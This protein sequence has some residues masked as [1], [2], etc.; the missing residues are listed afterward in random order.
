M[1]SVSPSEDIMKGFTTQLQNPADLLKKLKFDLA[2][3]ERAPADSYVA[4]DFFVTAEHLP[5]WVGNKQVKSENEILKVV[6]HI[7][8][9]AKHFKVRDKRHKSVTSVETR[10]DPWLD[11]SGVD[12]EHIYIQFQLEDGKF[13]GLELSALSIAK[14]VVEY[15][16]A[17]F[18]NKGLIG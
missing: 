14:M 6:S 7:A 11:E 1:A 16:E 18:E 2:R 9:G 15:W 12:G 10:C 8:N 13:S 4:F 17:Y 3:L 5:D